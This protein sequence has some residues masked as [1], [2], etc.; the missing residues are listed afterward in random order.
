[1]EQGKITMPP[2]RKEPEAM[3]ANRSSG[4]CRW[5]RSPPRA[6]RYSGVRP[7]SWASTSRPALETTR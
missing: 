6:T 4:R 5:K 2:V 3:G 7:V 1:M